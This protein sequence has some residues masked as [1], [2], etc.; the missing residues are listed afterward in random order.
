[1]SDEMNLEPKM[2]LIVDEHHMYRNIPLSAVSL[3]KS[4]TA[5]EFSEAFQ[6]KENSF[7]AQEQAKENRRESDRSRDGLSPEWDFIVAEETHN[8]SC[9]RYQRA[10]FQ[11][12]YEAAPQLFEEYVTREVK[13]V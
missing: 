8:L 4:K 10:Y 1:M 5:R 12:L 7:K 3:P 11:L 13:N 6:F 9:T 2:V